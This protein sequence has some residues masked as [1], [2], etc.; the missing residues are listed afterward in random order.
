VALGADGTGTRDNPVFVSVAA[1]SDP[2][3]TMVKWTAGILVVAWAV[4]VYLE[5][6]RKNDKGAVS[7]WAA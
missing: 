7:R 4:Q 6:D 3:W 2:M 5:S 1:K